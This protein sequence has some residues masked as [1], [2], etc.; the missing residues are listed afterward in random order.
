MTKAWLRLSNI[1][2]G[3]WG[4]EVWPPGSPDYNPLESYMLGACERTIDRYPY[5]TVDEEDFI[6]L[7]TLIL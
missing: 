7:M 4:K 5:N 3:L 1:L 6:E 2:P